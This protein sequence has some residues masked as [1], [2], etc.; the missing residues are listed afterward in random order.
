[1]NFNIKKLIHGFSLIEI[2]IYLAIFTTF[3]ILVINSFIVILTS[4]NTTNTNRKLLESGLSSMERLTREVRQAKSIDIANSNST[5][6]QLNS[7]NEANDPIVIKLTLENNDLNLYEDGNKIGNLLNLHTD[8]TSLNFRRIA[9]TKGEAVKIEMTIQ[10]PQD[11]NL[12]S[13]NFYDT[14]ILRGEY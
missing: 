13:E 7:T 2:I 5:T 6:L 9:T 11:K 1:M 10:D 12:R 8:L 4:F 14:V 3:S